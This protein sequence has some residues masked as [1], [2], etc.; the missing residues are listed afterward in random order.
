MKVLKFES[1]K[2]YENNA[3]KNG[4][5]E[6]DFFSYGAQDNYIWLCVKIA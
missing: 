1:F 3:N 4:V 6:K 2:T 5:Q